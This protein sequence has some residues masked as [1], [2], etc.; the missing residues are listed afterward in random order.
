[1]EPD[2]FD[3]LGSVNLI[4]S[5]YNHLKLKICSQLSNGRTLGELTKA[6]L[7]LTTS[8]HSAEP[9]VAQDVVVE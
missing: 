4:F 7:I 1:M 9:Q 3:D 2:R 8:C 6:I 5:F